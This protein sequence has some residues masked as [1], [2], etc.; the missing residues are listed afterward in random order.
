M[1]ARTHSKTLSKDSKKLPAGWRDSSHWGK[2]E[3][4]PSSPNRN[5][6]VSNNP[7]IHQ[8]NNPLIQSV[9]PGTHGNH[10]HSRRCSSLMALFYVTPITLFV[11]Q[12][13]TEARAK[14]AFR[15]TKFRPIVPQE[16]FNSPMKS[17]LLPSRIE[18]LTLSVH[19]VTPYTRVFCTETG[20]PGKIPAADRPFSASPP[21]KKVIH[22]D[23]QCPT[24]SLRL[25]P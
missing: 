2:A 8:S 4:S 9:P 21:R 3:S 22:M 14:P 13:C 19:S 10:A 18:A 17:H 7:T 12:P 16:S 1:L 20:Y 5:R 23:R 6:L 24:P 25:A 15:C 11:A